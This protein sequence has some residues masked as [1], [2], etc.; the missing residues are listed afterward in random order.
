MK[1]IELKYRKLLRAIFGCI[2]LTAVAFV[3]QA[4]YGVYENR[5]YEIKLTGTVVSKTTHLPIKGVKITVNAE[6]FGTGMT[7]EKGRFDFYASVPDGAYY[8]TYI[9]DVPY[10]ADSVRVYFAD[11]DSVANGNFK[12]KTVIINPAHKDE[13]KIL[14]ELENK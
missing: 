6:K 1:K 3:F 7:D 14:V 8:Y 12:D 5:L 4:C 10:K 9:D 2:S 13:V 11:I